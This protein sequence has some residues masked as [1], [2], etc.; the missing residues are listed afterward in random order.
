[1]SQ[2]DTIQ[3]QKTYTYQ[4]Y[5]QLPEGAPY[6]LINGQLVNEPSPTP[7][8]QD[9]SGKLLTFIN[10]YLNAN[11][12]VG[13][14]FVAPLDVYLENKE[15]FQPDLI[16]ISKERLNIIK[17]KNIQGA[18]DIVFEILSPSTAYYD[19]RH[20]KDIYA[21]HGVK[22]Y[23]IIDP[24][25]QSIEVYEQNNG[26]FEFSTKKVNNGKLSSMALKG[27]AVALEEIF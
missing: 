5:A 8:H 27:F 18:P 26:A 22:E 19:L 25:E 7:Y 14:A 13:K 24:M 4:D 12:L 16:F 11:H 3:K 20:K 23:W 9:I 6:E 15:T 10:N 1:M 21:K 2:I 17:E